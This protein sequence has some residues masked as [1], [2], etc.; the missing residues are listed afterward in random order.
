MP[1]NNLKV[2]L[3]KKRF[4]SSLVDFYGLGFGK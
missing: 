4:L 1:N 2:S 3:K